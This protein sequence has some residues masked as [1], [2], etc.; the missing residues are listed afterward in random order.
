M[1][2]LIWCIPNFSEGRREDVV[3]RIAGAMASASEVKVIRWEM[4]AD[5]NRAVVTF[6]GAPEDVRKS[7]LAGAREA[8][9]LIDLSRHAGGHP[10]IG[11][12]DVVPVVPVGDST[13]PE[14]VAL[15]RVIGQDMAAELGLP[16]YY[17]EHNAASE[18]RASLAHLRRGG[19]EAL[20]KC[21]LTGDRAPDVG[22]TTLHPTAGA[23]VVGA[24][25]PLVAYNVDLRTN[26]ISIADAIAS[27]IRRLR[28]EGKGMSG[29]RAIGVYLASRGIAQVST[30]ITRPEL[31]GIAEVYSFIEREA[32]EIG[33][34]VLRSEI[35]GAVRR[36][37]LPDNLRPAIRLLEF[38]EGQILDNWLG[39]GDR[40]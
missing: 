27:H 17:Y 29:V 25:G 38:D 11:A 34:E 15:A 22:P 9:G 10:R 2:R 35:I 3:L 28:N 36:R 24:R 32:R 14:A 6:I 16:V 7:M 30:N 5:H 4:D 21:G 37:D 19:F 1:S 31:T 13:M 18:S 39:T 23:V 33:V 26:D 8:V 20:R 12:V 40:G